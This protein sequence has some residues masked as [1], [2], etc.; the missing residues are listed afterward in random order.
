[1]GLEIDAIKDAI[2]KK[3][4]VINS[5]SAPKY[6]HL[7]DWSPEFKR[8]LPK[9]KDRVTQVSDSNQNVETTCNSKNSSNWS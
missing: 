7:Q 4:L 3:V 8:R 2:T 6:V 5:S 9:Y 1:M